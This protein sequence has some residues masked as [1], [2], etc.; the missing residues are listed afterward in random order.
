VARLARLEQEARVLEKDVVSLDLRI[1]GK[2]YVRLTEEAAATREA[3]KP[4]GKGAHI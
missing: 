3:A 1:P 2:L 4:H